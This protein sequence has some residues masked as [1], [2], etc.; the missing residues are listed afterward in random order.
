[1]MAC[2]VPIAA[3]AVGSLNDLLGDHPE[4]LFPPDN[5]HAMAGVIE[6]RL[7][8]RRTG[9]SI[10]PAW[11]DIATRLETVFRGVC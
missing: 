9:Y 6:R 10:V 8:D 1:M 5:V 3:A 2:D 4:W 7:T 11:C